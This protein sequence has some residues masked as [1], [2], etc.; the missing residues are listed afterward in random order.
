MKSIFKIC[1][2][3]VMFLAAGM[4]NAQ[5]LKFAHIDSQALIEAMPEAKA[6]QA[7]IEKEAKGLEDQ[8][9][10]LQKEYQTKL[11]DLS[12]NQDSLTEIVYQ[13]K[14][15]DLQ[16]LQQRIQNFNSSAQQ[17]LQQKQGELMQPIFAKANETIEAVAKEQGVIY[18]FDS[19]AVLYK[20]NASIDLLPLVKAKLGIQ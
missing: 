8:M 17:R 19:N 18:V 1:L 7:S 15:E 20:S 16:G 5:T 9:G 14:V 11:A 12:D 3:A 4:V 6:A 13:S 2:V 10:A